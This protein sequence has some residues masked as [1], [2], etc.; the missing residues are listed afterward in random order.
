VMTSINSKC[1]R[2]KHDR[3]PYQAVFGQSYHQQI[4]CTLSDMRSCETVQERLRLCPDDHLQEVAADFDDVINADDAAAADF[5][6]DSD[7]ES[8]SEEIVTAHSEDNPVGKRQATVL[9]IEKELATATANAR[10]EDAPVSEQLATASAPI[11]KELLADS[12]EGTPVGKKTATART[13]DALTAFPLAVETASTSNQLAIASAIDAEAKNSQSKQRRE[14]STSKG[15]SVLPVTMKRLKKMY[16]V[17]E[18]R[19]RGKTKARELITPRPRA[20]GRGAKKVMTL[21]TL[22]SNVIAA[23]TGV[24]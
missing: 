7:D 8:A 18:A 4:T 1:G 19:E 17:S 3:E 10:S 13:E 11:D 20:G 12:S 6:R 22:G 15:H 23:T 16:T 2:N 14:V 24:S 21:S 9:P 5:W